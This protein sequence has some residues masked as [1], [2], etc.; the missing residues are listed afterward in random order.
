MREIFTS[1]SV[2]DIEVFSHGKN[3]VALFE[4]K[5]KRNREHK[6]YL[7]KETILYLLDRNR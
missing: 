4:S 7:N 5:E 3:I 1:G 6:A 2:R